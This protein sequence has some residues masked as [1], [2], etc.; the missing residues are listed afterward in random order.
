M[1]QAFAFIIS[2]VVLIGFGG[3]ILAAI[4]SD[5]GEDDPHQIAHGDTFPADYCGIVQIDPADFS[6]D[7]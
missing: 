4:W 6:H 3:V 1:Q 5:A 7:R 2:A